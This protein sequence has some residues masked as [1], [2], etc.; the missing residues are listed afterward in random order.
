M[1][2]YKFQIVTD[3]GRTVYVCASCRKKAIRLFIEQ[4]GVSESYIKQHCIVRNKGIVEYGV[5]SDFL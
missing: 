3:A 2:I 4:S 1:K 5:R